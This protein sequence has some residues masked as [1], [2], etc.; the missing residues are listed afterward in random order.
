MSVAGMSSIRWRHEGGYETG[1]YIP[2]VGDIRQGFR[3]DADRG[4]TIV[5]N[6]RWTCAAPREDSGVIFLRNKRFQQGLL[7]GLIVLVIGTGTYV[8]YELFFK[9]PPPEPVVEASF[10]GFV[11]EPPQPAPS[12]ELV[13]QRRQPFRLEDHEGN[14]VVMFFGYTNCPDICPATL[15]YY[16]QVKRELGPLADR[17]RFVF[18]SV[19]PE[20]DTPEHLDRFVSRFDPSFYGLSGT[21]EET[22]RVTQDY[23]VYVEKVEDESSPVG[24]SVNHG[25]LS[26]VVDTDGN[27]HLAHPFGIDP[28]DIAADLRQLL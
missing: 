28:E 22:R 14:L 8:A 23:G 12:V 9:E 19:D 16:T 3:R 26:Y 2:G 7:L 4:P 5:Y 15:V 18:V 10:H 1:T 24:Y 27:L 17:V 21:L 6:N 11:L 13:D 20:Y 25:T